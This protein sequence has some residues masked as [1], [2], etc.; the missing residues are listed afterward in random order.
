MVGE[1][2]LRVISSL[3][4]EAGKVF[5]LGFFS[6]CGLFPIKKKRCILIT[7]EKV[8]IDHY[9]MCIAGDSFYSSCCCESNLRLGVALSGLGSLWGQRQ[10][11]SLSGDACMW[12]MSMSRTMISVQVWIFQTVKNVFQDLFWS[13][14]P[15]VGSCG[16]EDRI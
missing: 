11:Q 16:R 2:G 1:K 8:Y 6:L 15:M 4:C 10:G 9:N 12:F 5:Q 13:P 3:T 14:F 7:T